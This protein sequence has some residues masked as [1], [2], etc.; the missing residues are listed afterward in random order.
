[1]TVIKIKFKNLH[2]LI[3]RSINLCG[4]QS[5][6]GRRRNPDFVHFSTR[7]APYPEAQAAHETKTTDG[8][9]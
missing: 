8:G 7:H 9:L 5:V 2:K 4:L 3:D 6:F 1:M